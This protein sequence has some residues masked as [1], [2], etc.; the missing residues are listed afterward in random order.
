MSTTLERLEWF[1]SE[2][3][4]IAGGGGETALAREYANCV[5]V[6]AQLEALAVAIE[7]VRKC[8]DPS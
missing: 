7:T 2:L 6:R 3:E 4:R 5:F 1:D 8:L